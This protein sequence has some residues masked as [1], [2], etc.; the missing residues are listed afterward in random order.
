MH[1]RLT[2][3]LIDLI[4]E[5][6]ALSIDDTLRLALQSPSLDGDPDWPAACASFASC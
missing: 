3:F 5:T 2:R 6:N 1:L 4:S